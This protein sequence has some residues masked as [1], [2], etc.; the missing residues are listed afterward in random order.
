MYT[1]VNDLCDYVAPGV[2]VIAVSP[3]RVIADSGNS[4]NKV[5]RA[6]EQDWGEL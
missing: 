6:T 4:G 2:K 1:V 3:G 5:A